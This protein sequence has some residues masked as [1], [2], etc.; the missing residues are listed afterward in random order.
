[1]RN[2]L[3]YFV[4]IFKSRCILKHVWTTPSSWGALSPAVED[5]LDTAAVGL[6]A[7]LPVVKAIQLPTKSSAVV[8]GRSSYQLR[9]FST[10]SWLI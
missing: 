4:R 1:M 9:A 8:H 5:P 2:I 7:S 10:R 3:S 6:W